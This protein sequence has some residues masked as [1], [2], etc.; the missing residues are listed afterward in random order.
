MSQGAIANELNA[1]GVSAV[2]GSWHR[3]TVIRVLRQAVA[4]KAD[5]DRPR[6]GGRV[7]LRRIWAACLPGWPVVGRKRA[8]VATQRSFVVGRDVRVRGCPGLL[9]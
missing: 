1:A 5:D 9:F 4:R 3:G 7:G 2:G 8:H 6:G